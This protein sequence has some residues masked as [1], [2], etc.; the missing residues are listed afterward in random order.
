MANERAF[1]YRNVGTKESPVWEKWFQKTVSDA[2]L[3][4]DK[5]G[6]TKTIVDFVNEKIADLIGGAPETYDTLKELADYIASHEEVADALNEAIGKKA[7]K[8]EILS[9]PIRR[10]QQLLSEAYR[11]DISLLRAVLIQEI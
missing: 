7:S 4:S 2:V 1:S 8:E 5:E 11:L 6:E 10:R 3:M 9:I